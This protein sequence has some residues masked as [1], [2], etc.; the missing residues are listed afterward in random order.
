METF[1]ERSGQ[2]FAWS[3]SLLVWLI[4]ID[5]FMRYVLNYSFIWIVE[6]EI[7]FFAFTFLFGFAYTFKHDKHV[8]V[9][10]FYNKLKEKSKARV[11]LLGGI[12]FLVPWCVISI[13]VCFKYFWTSFLINEHSRQPG[14]LPYLFLLKACLFIGFSLLLIQAI[15]SIINS[16]K[17]Y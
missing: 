11:N 8:R 3:T 1:I 17:D 9:D 16:I 12:L 7:Y 6:L 2:L 4:C 10:I 5:V 14:G 15:V 13:Y